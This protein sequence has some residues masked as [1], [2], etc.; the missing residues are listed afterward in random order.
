[1]FDSFV[2]IIVIS[3]VKC[4]VTHQFVS[5]MGYQ[6]K[7][8]QENLWPLTTQKEKR[9]KTFFCTSE[10]REMTRDMTFGKK[11]ECTMG[12]DKETI[13]NEKPHIICNHR[14]IGL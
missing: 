13:I 12:L 14:K 10:N 8:K 11:T 2:I 1:M 5:V 6:K 3:A 4:N 9:D 7:K